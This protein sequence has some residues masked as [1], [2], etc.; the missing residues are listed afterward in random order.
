MRTH[1][2]G[3]DA[4]NGWYKFRLRRRGKVIDS[5][6]VK[7][8]ITNEARAAMARAYFDGESFPTTW[9]VGL[10]GYQHP[11][12]G[13]PKDFNTDPLGPPYDSLKPLTRDIG[14]VSGINITASA[15]SA[16]L[17]GS[18]LPTVFAEVSWNKAAAQLGPN[19]TPQVPA[20]GFTSISIS[21]DA[22]CYGFYIRDS[23]GA[24]LL[25]VAGFTW[26]TSRQSGITGPIKWLAGQG[27]LI[28]GDVL[29]VAYS[30]GPNV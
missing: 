20:G 23:G 12:F 11:A 7:N 9:N 5:G 16:Q 18:T 30:I 8:V 26:V 1:D 17:G 4:V 13:A 27:P 22:A 29:D 28:S 2:T 21:A 15:T 6:V 14:P 10:I 19:N 24:V 25:S 3:H